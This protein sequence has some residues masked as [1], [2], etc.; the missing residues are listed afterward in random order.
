LDTSTDIE[1]GRLL[2]TTEVY[3]VSKEGSGEDGGSPQQ[4][5]YDTF[6]TKLQGLYDQ[7]NTASKERD[8][9]KL[10][11]EW[12]NSRLQNEAVYTVGV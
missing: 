4:S 7:N 1:K 10:A 3:A 8:F 2:K 9:M 5:I 11:K 6:Q 12:N